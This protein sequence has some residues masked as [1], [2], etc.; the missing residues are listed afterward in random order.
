MPIFNY[1]QYKGRIKKPAVVAILEHANNCLPRRL[2]CFR[3]VYLPR[4][5]NHLADYFA[6]QASAAAKEAEGNPLVPL[7]HVAL[8]PF[9]LA[10]T[11]GFIIQQG[12]ALQ[13]PAFVL[14]ERPSPTPH[15]LHVLLRRHPHYKWV[16]MDYIALAVS[17][18]H[19][20]SVGYKPT[21]DALGGGLLSW[22]CSAAVAAAGSAA[23]LWQ[24][25]LGNR[26]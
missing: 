25:A 9:H 17:S 12:D 8:P 5:C 15:E 6:G 16:A 23:P 14:T 18:S 21:V 1:L 26:Y 4:E 20:L 3:L 24:F 7:H 10:Q 19:C 22:Q 2:V 13:T 11:L